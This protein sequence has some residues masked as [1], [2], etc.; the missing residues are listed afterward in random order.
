MGL[1]AQ[2]SDPHLRDDGAGPFHDPAQALRH[3]FAQI[4][5]MDAKPDA[6]VLTGN[7][8]DR[9]AKGYAHAL[10]VL[11]QSRVPLWPMPGNHDDPAGFRMAFDGCAEFAP[12]HL[13]YTAPIAD[14]HL[15]ALDSTL[16]NGCPG[17]DRAR[18]DWLAGV[19]ANSQQP[20]LL[21][22]HHPPFATGAPHLDM[23]GFQ[24]ADALLR[25]IERS[26]GDWPWSEPVIVGRG[27]SQT[28]PNRSC[29]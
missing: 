23:P 28:C 27:T 15:I 16:S 3:A 4:D 20:S 21:A 26:P 9:S 18:L 29:L 7:I 17:L 24:N 25:L 8:I 12:D 5:A 11:L 10:P 19:L 14:L 1:I 2:L 6:I 22:L 13:S